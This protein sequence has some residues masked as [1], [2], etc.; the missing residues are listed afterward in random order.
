[1]HVVNAR[2]SSCKTGLVNFN[3]QEGHLILQERAREPHL[4]IHRPISKGGGG[5]IELT[6]T[7]LFRHKLR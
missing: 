6:R 4:C 2:R 1:M 5:G 3:P 7:P